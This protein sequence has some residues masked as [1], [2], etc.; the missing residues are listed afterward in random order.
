MKTGEQ[1]GPGY[2]A[3]IDGLRALAVLAVVLFHLWAPAL[4]GGFVG[5]D[6]FF[7]IS[8]FVVTGSMMGT[9]FA[10]LGALSLHFYARRL[11][12]IMPALILMLL[13]TIVA[14]T[15]FVPSS[16]LSNSIPQVA[17][18]AFFGLSNI[19]LATDTDSYFGP[20]AGYNP[21][22]HSWSLGVEEQFYLIFPFLIF[23]HQKL[24]GARMPVRRVVRLVAG[25]SIAS[26][27]IHAVLN[28]VA[29]KF[30]FYLIVSRFWELG[31]GML[32]CLT[33]D[34]W[35]ESGRV[36]RGATAAAGL[37]LIAAGLAW[38]GEIGL[39]RNLLAVA[40]TAA[41]LGHV[42]ARPEARVSRLFAAGPIVAIGKRSYAL[43]LW[44]WPVF[45]LFRWTTGLH[46]AA[47]MLAALGISVLLAALS[48]ALVEHP[49]HRSARIAAMPRRRVVIASVA[50][51]LI[52]F[53][54]AQAIIANHD[55]L[56][57]SRTG[58]AQDW[59]AD[60]G[61]RLDPALSRCRVVEEGRAAGGAVV[62]IWRAE[63]CAARPETIRVLGDSHATAYTPAL[64]QLVAD[65]G[66]TVQLWVRAGCPVY[67]LI[68]PA[69]DTDKC[70]RFYGAIL[71]EVAQHSRPGDRVFLPGLRIDRFANQYGDD[72]DARM[73]DRDASPL[74]VAQARA[75][76]TQLARSGTRLTI[77]APKPI[78]PSPTFRCTDW[79][80]RDNPGCAGGTRIARERI[81]RRRAPILGAM[82]DLQSAV[83]QLEIW[84]PLPTLCPGTVCQAMPDGRPLFF[85]GDHLSG[86]GNDR[87]YP[88]LRRTLTD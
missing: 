51:T 34:R 80:N 59:Y 42:V 3:A 84:D 38:P 8:G 64:R 54:I 77:E 66:V 78:F 35:R 76:L 81:E 57:L 10:S 53:G 30:G 19:V 18:F 70:R 46:T 37:A 60:D 5:V 72:P 7:V 11:V 32:L 49:I 17:R 26:L 74:G 86:H 6:I 56:T 82:R 14:A 45:V 47:L 48:Y 63:G 36:R 79:F 13:S 55:R 52:A 39:A 23:W 4:P 41:L 83:P 71:D 62:R 65:R 12:R 44:H 1:A 29:P 15:L 61:H 58:N 20:Q 43:Y 31:V 22:T 21:F 25:L 2:V 50:A 69:P 85:D 16:W 87:I 67:R 68:D 33:L 9:R 27:A 40:G 73:Q 28:L 24:Q 75:F 88:E